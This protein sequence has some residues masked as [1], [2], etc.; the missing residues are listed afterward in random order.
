MSQAARKHAPATPRAAYRTLQGWALGTLIDCGVVTECE[1]H[2]HRRDRA[3][4][5]AWN[6]ACETAQTEPFAG[7]EPEACIMAMQE[8]LRGIGDTCPD[9]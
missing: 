3:D 8:V 1:H 6:R 4:P 2:G 7:S 9:C 5:E